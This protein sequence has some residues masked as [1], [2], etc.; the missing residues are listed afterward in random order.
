MITTPLRLELSPALIPPAHTTWPGSVWIGEVWRDRVEALH[1]DSE[2]TG[3]PVCCR[4]NNA[5]GY[6][7]ARLLVRSPGRIHGFIDL[8]ISN[9][10]LD[11]A[12]L[13]QHV[14]RAVDA[15]SAAD[16]ARRSRTVTVVICTRDRPQLLATALDAV[17]ALDYP[18]FDVV[19]VD[20]ASATS[21]TRDHVQGHADPR[22]RLVCEPNP[23]VARARNT[24]LRAATGDIV[25][26]VDDDAVV[27]RYWLTALMAGFDRAGSVG[28]VSGLVPAGEIRTPAQAEFERRVNWSTASTARVFDWNSPPQDVPLFP[29]AVGEYGTGA[30]FALDRET[31]LQLGGFDPHLGAGAPTCGGEDLDIFFRVLRSGHQLV[32][33]PAAVAWHRH[34]DSDA[35]LEDQMR[36]YG[37]GLGAWLAKIA[38]NPATAALAAKVVVTRGPAL[39]R[40]LGTESHAI[41]PTM[42]MRGAWEYGR[43]RL[44]TRRELART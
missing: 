35:S 11:F 15:G 10:E 18:D 37:M 33:E 34:R 7:R 1:H 31:A 16:S 14:A 4:L 20:N 41:A 43:A 12:D 17:L 39:R 26:F 38:G 36:G 22:V 32:L 24:G 6:G 25:A 40:H 23:G 29:F 28:C 21:E 8:E 9:G 2:T 13:A 44:R 30:N 3:Q 42:M 19:V 5:D 27:D